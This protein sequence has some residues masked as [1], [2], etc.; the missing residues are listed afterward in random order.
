LKRVGMAD[1]ADTQLRRFSKGMLQRIGIA[2]AI[3]HDPKVVFLDE[4]MSGL[5]P[6][7]RHEVRVLIEDL[8]DEGRTVFFSTHIL[9]DAETLCD[10]VAVVHK[11]E[12]R[13]VNSISEL[14]AATAGKY[15]IVAQGGSAQSLALWIRCRVNIAVSARA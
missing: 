10:R 6:V 15:E 3:L 9:S 2:Q 12:L 14:V 1:S 5:D 8:R 11:G 7:G 13:G 4:P